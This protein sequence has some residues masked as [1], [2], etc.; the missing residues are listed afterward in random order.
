M[1][2]STTVI[3]ADFGSPFAHQLTVAAAL[4]HLPVSVDYVSCDS[5]AAEAP[6]ISHNGTDVSKCP[7]DALEYLLDIASL[8]S[9]SSSERESESDEPHVH[10]LRPA[11][12]Q[13]RK[14][15]CVFANTADAMGAALIVSQ[16]PNAQPSAMREVIGHM[17]LLDSLVTGKFA[18]GDEASFADAV[19]VPHL[20]RFLLT[21]K[22]AGL[23]GYPNLWRVY[24]SACRNDEVRETIEDYAFDEIAFARFV[25]AQTGASKS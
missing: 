15:A 4:A 22:G 1:T 23:D 19:L 24:E 9:T 16:R 13:K 3:H 6:V 5:P 2:G 7:S 17:K 8:E 11:D 18:V 20:A 12:Q 10:D 14:L 21:T 25:A